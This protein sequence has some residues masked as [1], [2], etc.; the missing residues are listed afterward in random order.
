MES[1]DESHR[2][3]PLLRHHR[4]RTGYTQQEL[5]DFSTISIRAIRDLE[6]GRTRQ[7]HKD[8]VLLLADALRLDERDR[9]AL[10]S[11]AGRTSGRHCALTAQ[12]CPPPP[13]PRTPILG[14]QEEVEALASTLASPGRRW[15][16]VSGVPGVGRTRFVAE[17]VRRHH[18]DDPVPVLWAAQYDAL[19]PGEPRTG[20]ADLADQACE[21]LFG[22]LGGARRE[23]AVAFA[24]AVGNRRILLVLD[25]P[26]AGVPDR[27]V[28]AFLLGRCPQTRVIAVA[29]RPCGSPGEEVFPLQP[30]SPDTA[31]EVLAWYMR[32]MRLAP[33]S[34]SEDAP[35]LARICALLDHLPGA[36]VHASS[37]LSLY[38]PADLLAHLSE[39]PLPFLSPVT[40]GPDMTDSLRRS[41]AACTPDEAAVLRLLRAAAGGAPDEL[42]RVAGLSLA[43]CGRALNGLITRGLARSD[44]SAGEVRVHPLNLVRALQAADDNAARAVARESVALSV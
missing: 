6:R 15:V 25:A 5:A 30:L 36:L 9:V 18:A 39:N 16:T 11:A 38:D 29:D 32:D 20:L 12:V 1:P 42:A 43:A 8:T 10:L 13:P 23:R 41:V 7:P 40:G 24:E 22:A 17:V 14:R 2:F 34:Q 19:P 27:E 44:R 28:L 26:G 31:F 33:A 3:A 35:H 4:S 37:W 21:A